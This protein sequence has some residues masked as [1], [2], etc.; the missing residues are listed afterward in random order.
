MAREFG[1]RVPVLL[2]MASVLFMLAAPTEGFYPSL[3]VS[4]GGSLRQTGVAVGRRK[5][6]GVIT[7]SPAPSLTVPR[8]ATG[9]ASG[10]N[11]ESTNEDPDNQ[12][13]GGGKEEGLEPEVVGDWAGGEELQIMVMRE[14]L[15]NQYITARIKAKPVFLP[16]E[17]AVG[18]ARRLGYW[19]S[20]EEWLDWIEMGENHNP[21]I[22]S[23]PE[24][25]YG[26]RGEWK[27]WCYFLGVKE[28][29]SPEE[30]VSAAWRSRIWLVRRGACS[31]ER[32][33]GAAWKRRNKPV[34]PL[35][36]QK[37]P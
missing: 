23:N 32:L 1:M 7:G 36:R 29:C 18:W 21:Y 28:A 8:M 26:R 14:K 25:Y 2:A 5:R 11:E 37:K 30:L 9:P 15:E 3:Q 10:G 17:K 19:D 4:R 6:D 16:F 34:L 20:K 24:Q 12:Q 33:V 35:S 22:P 27:G 13:E 31:P